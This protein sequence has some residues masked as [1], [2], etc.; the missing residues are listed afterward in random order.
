M[1][2]ALVSVPIDVSF[3]RPAAV[4]P[5]IVP[6]DVLVR[7]VIVFWLPS[8]FCPPLIRPLLVRLPMLPLLLSPVPSPV[9]VPLLMRVPTAPVL[10]T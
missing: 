1:R 9:S 8:P 7:L 10:A 2:P 6:V 4:P 5:R 3:C